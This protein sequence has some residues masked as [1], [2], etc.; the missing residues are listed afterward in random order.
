MSDEI[1]DDIEIDDADIDEDAEV[2]GHVMFAEKKGFSLKPDL[3]APPCPPE[4]DDWERGQYTPNTNEPVL[5]D[6]C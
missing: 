5:S 1:S 6:D 2:E 4:L 3:L